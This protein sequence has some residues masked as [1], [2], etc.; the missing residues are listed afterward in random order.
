MA[1]LLV[2]WLLLGKID[3]VSIYRRRSLNYLELYFVI[4]LE[5]FAVGSIYTTY[6]SRR[7][8]LHQQ[9]FALVMVGSAFIVFLCILASCI[10]QL[11][12]KLISKRRSRNRRPHTLLESEEVHQEIIANIPTQSTVQVV[13]SPLGFNELREPLITD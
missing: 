1:L 7:P 6:F 3:T 11:V 4:N 2:L 8:I 13:E 5:V 10:F 9:C 12:L